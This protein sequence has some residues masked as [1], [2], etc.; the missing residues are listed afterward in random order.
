[1]KTEPKTFAVGSP[2]RIAVAE[3][4]RR[5]PAS[6]T[7]GDSPTAEAIAMK[8]AADPVKEP[9]EIWISG[10]DVV[11]DRSALSNTPKPSPVVVTTA[12]FDA[13]SGPWSAMLA[14]A[15]VSDSTR[16]KETP[17]TIGFGPP[18][19]SEP[20]D[21]ETSALGVVLDNVEFVT[22]MSWNN[23]EMV[24]FVAVSSGPASAAVEGATSSPA[25]APLRASASRNSELPDRASGPTLTVALLSWM[26]GRSCVVVSCAHWWRDTTGQHA[27]PVVPKKSLNP[28]EVVVMVELLAKIRDPARVTD[29][30]AENDVERRALKTVPARSAVESTNDSRGDGVVLVSVALSPRK[31]SPKGFAGVL[32]VAVGLPVWI[33]VRLAESSGP[34]RVID[35]VGV[36]VGVRNCRAVVTWLLVPSLPTNEKSGTAVPVV[37]RPAPSA[38]AN[39]ARLASLAVNAVSLAN[40]REPWSVRFAAPVSRS[41]CDAVSAAGVIGAAVGRR[42]KLMKGFGVAL[43]RLPPDMSSSG[44][45]TLS[46]PGGVTCRKGPLIVTDAPF[47]ASRVPGTESLEPGS[48]PTVNA[49]EFGSVPSTW[50]PPMSETKGSPAVAITSL[51]LKTPTMRRATCREPPPTSRSGPASATVEAS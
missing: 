39:A 18:S 44:P 7:V 11:L 29:V 23:V 16:A 6:R 5:G 41:S 13:N 2:L 20:P 21:R 45:P 26:S 27:T 46:T 32:P 17:P 50:A 47:S 49:S 3:A 19:A 35:G 31:I 51:P 12:P 9:P 4:L 38:M 40:N 34:E 14:P 15:P 24:L 48:E 10:W 25:G 1:M 28:L 33:V 43:V 36:P 42:P 30:G 8:F 37:V 22:W